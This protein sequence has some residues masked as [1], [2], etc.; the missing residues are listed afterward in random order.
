MTTANVTKTLNASAQA[1]WEQLSPFDR[2]KPGGNITAVEYQGQGVGMLRTIQMGD[3]E[4]VER[5]EVLDAATTTFSYR[6]L[7]DDSPLPFTDYSATVII[8]DNQDGTST[9]DWTGTFE[10]R[11]VPEAD[12]I[13]VATGIYAGAIKGTRIALGLD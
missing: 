12:A 2:L 5:L 8:R 1:V 11:G 6:I 3:G 10:P 13:K 7:N 9:V 4:I